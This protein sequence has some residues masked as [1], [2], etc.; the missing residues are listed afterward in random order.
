MSV[1]DHSYRSVGEILENLQVAREDILLAEALSELLKAVLRRDVGRKTLSQKAAS[2]FYISSTLPHSNHGSAARRVARW[3]RP[4]SA[5]CGSSGSESPL[6][7][8]RPR[9]R[10]ITCQIFRTFGSDGFFIE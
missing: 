3:R 9:R 6:G 7:T 2:L 1:D 4:W 10:L 8:A 5:R